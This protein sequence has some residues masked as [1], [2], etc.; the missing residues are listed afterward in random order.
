M[1]D[2]IP[3]ALLVPPEV[4]AEAQNLANLRAEWAKWLQEF[5]WSHYCTLTFR[6]ATSV[7]GA[8][9][10]LIWFVRQLA[11]CAYNRVEWFYVIETSP[12]NL[13]HLHTLLGQTDHLP[14][15][16]VQQAWRSGITRIR[17]YDP[18]RG[19]TRY[20]TKAIT[21]AH[22]EYDVSRHLTTASTHVGSAADA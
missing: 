19:A 14:V 8:K 17:R 11:Q 6:H 20:V 16:C 12:G 5:K 10:E 22:V 13:V 15:A 7:E 18:R 3:R 1:R 2:P 9:R 4:L 21:T